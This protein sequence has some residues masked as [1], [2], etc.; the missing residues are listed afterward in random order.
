MKMEHKKLSKKK[1]K[2]LSKL[3][4]YSFDDRY[5][6]NAF[7]DVYLVEEDNDDHF[8]GNPMSPYITRDGYVEYVLTTDKG[9]KKHIQAQRIVAGLYL[10][11]VPGKDF[12]NHKNG[13][14]KDNH[15][16]NLK[17]TT[18]SE[19]IQHTFDKLGRKPWNL[20]KKKT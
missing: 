1:V 12:V 10:E 3:K 13:N 7:G 11:D 19:N 15:Y 18:V 6:V 20:G 17:Y 9:K 2:N 16:S 5:V 8:I 14:K 4:L